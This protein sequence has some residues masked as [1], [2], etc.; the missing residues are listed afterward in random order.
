MSVLDLDSVG[1]L[2]AL[3]VVS[4]AVTLVILYLMKFIREKHSRRKYR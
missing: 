3:I 4:V 2:L 1:I